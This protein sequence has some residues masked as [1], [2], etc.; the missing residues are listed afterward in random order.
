MAI[1][2]VTVYGDKILRKKVDDVK[3]V[4]FKTIRIN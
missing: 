3:D 4:D 1:L 2:P